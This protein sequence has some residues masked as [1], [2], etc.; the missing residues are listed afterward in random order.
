MIEI[1]DLRRNLFEYLGHDDFLIK[2]YSL[3]EDGKRGYCVVIFGKDSRP[4]PCY[5][6]FEGLMAYLMHDRVDVSFLT[7][8]LPD[9]LKFRTY[10]LI[11]QSR[12]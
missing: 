1:N 4:L 3:K 6:K 9:H 2:K 8:S 12:K 5:S 10:E 7:R 11:D